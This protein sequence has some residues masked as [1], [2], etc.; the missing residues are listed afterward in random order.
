M[1]QDAFGLI[2]T[3]DYHMRLKDLTLERTVASVPFGG[4]YR[5]IDFIMSNLVNSGITNVGI[6]TQK[7]YRS[8]M[9]HLGSGGPWDLQRKRDGLYI[10][11]PFNSGDMT[12]I[13]KGTIDAFRSAL[14][15]LKHVPFRYCF[16]MGSRTIYNMDYQKMLEKHIETQADITCLYYNDPTQVADEFGNVGE[17]RYMMQED[18]RINHMEIDAKRPLSHNASMDCMIMDKQLLEFLVE[19]A[20]GSGYTDFIRDVLQKKL[21]ELYIYGYE[22]QGY[23]ARITGIT[24]FFRANLD[25]L[26]REV[27]LDLFDRENRIYTKVKDE[28]PAQYRASAMVKNALVADGCIIEGAVENCV[29]SRGVHIG[30]GAVLKNCVIM[31][32]CEVQENVEMEN[33]ILDKEVTVRQ[34]RRLVGPEDYPVVVRKGSVV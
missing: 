16:L 34:G 7:N 5:V 27:S 11:P 1:I 4:R 13:Y 14:D 19:E 26:K 31:Q 21:K 33:V 8:L 15:Y 29:L 25:L 12:G 32:A 24:S 3:S 9:D 20:V 22:Y 18:G 30:K 6:I 2:Y 10:L 28:V 17:V 23:V